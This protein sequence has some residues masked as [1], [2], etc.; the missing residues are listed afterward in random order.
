MST[1]SRKRKNE[2]PHSPRAVERALLPKALLPVYIELSDDEPDA[3]TAETLSRD[4]IVLPWWL[5]EQSADRLRAFLDYRDA[6]GRVALARIPLTADWGMDDNIAYLCDNSTPLLLWS[7]GTLQS[8]TYVASSIMLSP[9]CDVQL[10]LLR[11]LDRDALALLHARSFPAPRDTRSV[12]RASCSYTGIDGIKVFSEIYDATSAYTSRASMRQ[13]TPRELVIGDVVLVEAK[14]IRRN[15][16]TRSRGAATKWQAWQ[17]GFAL[18]SISKLVP[19]ITV[20]KEAELDD[21]IPHLSPTDGEQAI[22][23]DTDE[24]VIREREELK[25]ALAAASAETKEFL[26]MYLAGTLHGVP[27]DV[28]ELIR[29]NK[30]YRRDALLHEYRSRLFAERVYLTILE[31]VDPAALPPFPEFVAMYYI[32]IE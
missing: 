5:A 27:E 2:E 26:A 18:Q 10:G 13:I 1:P 29:L 14:V 9:G 22:S 15:I 23:Y 30:Q 4:A 21:G 17:V 24:Q 32:Q 20:K 7:V 3:E 11:D 6:T 25:K 31:L 28:K 16:A 8:I 12:F 19:R